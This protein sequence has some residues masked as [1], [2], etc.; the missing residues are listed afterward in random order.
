MESACYGAKIKQGRT[1][2]MDK[3]G[4]GL[5]TQVMHPNDNIHAFYV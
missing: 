2:L 1:L 3:R 4:M 5:G